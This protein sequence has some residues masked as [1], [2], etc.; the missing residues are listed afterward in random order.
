[1]TQKKIATGAISEQKEFLQGNAK[2]VSEAMGVRYFQIR[3]KINYNFS[4][5]VLECCVCVVT[6]F[7]NISESSSHPEP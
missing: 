7:R 5:N 4:V 2:P 1:V 6:Q 3:N